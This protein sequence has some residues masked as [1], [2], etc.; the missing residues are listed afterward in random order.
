MASLYFTMTLKVSFFTVVCA[1][2]DYEE[3]FSNFFQMLVYF[4]FLR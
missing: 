4:N 1:V 2:I 3:L